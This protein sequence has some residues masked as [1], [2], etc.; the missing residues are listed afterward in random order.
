MVIKEVPLHKFVY[1]ELTENHPVMKKPYQFYI[2]EPINENTSKLTIEL[3]WQSK[4]IFHKLIIK[5]LGVKKQFKNR[6]ST[7]T[8]NLK[9]Y[10]NDRSLIN[11]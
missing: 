9:S 6:V 1:S 7:S 2:I 3:Y 11:L 4:T 8:N 10:L 5:I